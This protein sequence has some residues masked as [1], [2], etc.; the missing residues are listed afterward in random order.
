MTKKALHVFL[1][2]IVKIYYNSKLKYKLM[3]SFSII[4]IVSILFVGL[5]SYYI[6][7]NFL[8]EDEK[9]FLK[10]SMLQLNNTIEYFFEIY[11]NKSEMIFNNAELQNA[12]VKKNVNL[13]DIVDTHK[14][15]S[16]IIRQMTDDVK[17]PLMKNS[18]YLG[19]VL[20]VVI[21]SNNET[22]V[23]DGQEI[24]SFD[25]IKDEKWCKELYSSNELFTWESNVTDSK[26]NRYIT[27]NRRLIDFKTSK[28]IG[29]LRV[30]IP[31]ERFKNVILNNIQDNE[32]MLFYLDNNMGSIVQTGTGIQNYSI[33]ADDVSALNI[34]KP[35]DEVKI[36]RANFI[37]GYHISSITGWKLVYVIPTNLITGKVKTI[38]IITIITALLTILICI[39]T[40]TIVSEFITK[41]IAILVNKTNRIKENDMKIHTIIS[42]DDE[43]GQLDKNFNSMIQ[44]INDLIENEYKWKLSV[45]K[46]YVELLQEQINPHMLYNSLTMIGVLARKSNNTEISE[47][48]N[49][50]IN[51]YK[52]V[53]NK[54]Q[55]AS[56]VKSEI[57]MVVNYIDIIKLVYNLDIETI[58][59]IDDRIMNFYSIKLFLQPIVE[60]AVIHGI[61]PVKAGIILIRGEI[62]GDRL[63]FSVS[64]NGI[65]MDKDE[66]QNLR[67]SIKNGNVNMGYGMSN[68]AKRIKLF[69]GDKYDIDVKETIGGGTTV[70][71]N[72]PAL[73]KD[74]VI[75]LIE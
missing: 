72:I 18:Y 66:L 34:H 64:D 58:L 16:K 54:G 24:M 62:K 29:V 36:D 23:S 46:I 39:L 52:G 17:Y 44:R 7:R 6:A 13:V 11:M 48:A 65:G 27:M 15:I 38:S 68:V 33:S 60:N 74:E 37:I 40:T 43:I 49:N 14:N 10:Q 63:Q 4:I 1:R 59:E 56:S 8:I 3:F 19:G 26:N 69:F 42:G 30:F 35:I 25:D 70:V 22:L 55:I 61:K 41:R 67:T 47:T 71:I 5:T 21:Y 50:L 51:F 20:K 28:D 32:Y 57:D 2:R 75:K 45:N 73:K 12:L 53:L 9:K 31:I